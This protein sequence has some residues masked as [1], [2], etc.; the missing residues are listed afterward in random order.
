[1]TLR[2]NGWS[3]WLLSLFVAA[4]LGLAG[5]GGSTIIATSAR[6]TRVET[7]QEGTTSRLERIENKLE[8]VL[9]RI[10]ELILRSR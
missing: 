4:I 7:Q 1:M 6:V 10:D 9:E 2:T 3:K 5:W 8:R